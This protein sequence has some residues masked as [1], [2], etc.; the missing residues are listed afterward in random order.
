LKS[1]L[2]LP[3]SKTMLTMPPLS[4]PRLIIRPFVMDDFDDVHT[5]FDV[6]LDAAALHTDKL[7]S[8]AERA[9]WLQWSTLNHLQLAK[10][11]QPP[12]GDRAVQ[13]KV[14]GELIGSCGY[15]PCLAPFEQLPYFG[16][17][18][19]GA[20]LRPAPTVKNYTPEFGL[21][22]AISP[23]Y[24]GQGFATEA[25]QALLDYA[26]QHLHLKRVVATTDTDNLASIGVMKKLGM[27]VE[28]NPYP[29]P[30]WL[31]VVG[32]IENPTP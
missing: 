20:G 32:V 14:T 5:L 22:Y 19:A 4:T 2:A 1:S 11:Y 16:G 25:A 27:L 6:E 10:L 31:Q 9:Q 21:F 29:E 8:L 26:F 12:Y 7:D 13:L 30:A 24:Q 15:V 17:A 23:R 28:R 3:E 18:G